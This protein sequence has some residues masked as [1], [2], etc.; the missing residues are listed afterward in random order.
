[1]VAPKEKALK[2]QE[3][4]IRNS[5]RLENLKGFYMPGRDKASVVDSFGWI[6][7]LASLAGVTIHG[8]GRFFTRNGKEK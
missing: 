2:C 7:V 5:G 1:M 3:C 8:L 6:A 4:H